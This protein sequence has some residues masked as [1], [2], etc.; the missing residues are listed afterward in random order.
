MPNEMTPDL[1]AHLT[2]EQQKVHMA[3]HLLEP[4]AG[5]VVGGLLLEL[6]QAKQA[7]AEL[8]AAVADAPHNPNCQSL[9][10]QYPP[11]PAHLSGV[12]AVADW[13]KTSQRIPYP[14]NCWKSETT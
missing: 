14:C 6:A 13:L 1:L 12:T 2:P 4:P 5:D 8:R 3:R 9:V 11:I 10:W 7:L